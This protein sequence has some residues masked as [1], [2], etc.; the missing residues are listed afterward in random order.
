M[1][2][3]GLLRACAVRRRSTRFFVYE[4]RLRSY[5][6]GWRL[7]KIWILQSEWWLRTLRLQFN[8]LIRFR[9]C[10]WDGL[11]SHGAGWIFLRQ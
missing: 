6:N 2:R 3:G 8:F 7:H 5:V 4:Q 9:C 10:A 11:E 1:Q